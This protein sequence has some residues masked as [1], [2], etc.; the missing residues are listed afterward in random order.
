MLLTNPRGVDE[1]DILK[2]LGKRA[3]LQAQILQNYGYLRFIS[4]ICD[5]MREYK[6]SCV[7][8][9]C[10]LRIEYNLHSIFKTQT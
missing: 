9:L 7:V 3:F 1:R 2:G 6:N 8:P 5:Q 10:S 4:L